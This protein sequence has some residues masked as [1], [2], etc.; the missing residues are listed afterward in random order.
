MHDLGSLAIAFL[1]GGR[2]SHLVGTSETWSSLQPQNATCRIICGRYVCGL[3]FTVDVTYFET[4]SRGVPL[5]FHPLWVNTVEP[6]PAYSLRGITALSSLSPFCDSEVFSSQF[7]H[8]FSLIMWH[9]QSFHF[10][11]GRALQGALLFPIG[12]VRGQ[13]SE[14]R[15][16]HGQHARSSGSGILRLCTNCAF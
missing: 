5:S 16:R 12:F 4:A 1:R 3:T 14:R 9:S 7:M 15:G 2:R 6:G 11:H 8:I 10:Q 13:E